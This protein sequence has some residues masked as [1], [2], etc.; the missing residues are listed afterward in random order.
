M[1]LVPYGNHRSRP[2]AILEVRNPSAAFS[3]AFGI[4]TSGSV[5]ANGAAE[6][7]DEGLKIVE[8]EL[9]DDPM[10]R[11]RAEIAVF[12]FSDHYTTSNIVEFTPARFFTAPRLRQGGPTPLNELIC[13]MVAASIERREQIEQILDRSQEANWIFLL[14][15]AFPTDPEYEPDAIKAVN[16]ALRC[17][18]HLFPIGCGSSPDMNYLQRISQPQRRP[19]RMR[20]IKKFFKYVARSVS[21]RS[22]SVRD[23]F[24]FEDP[25]YRPDNLGGWAS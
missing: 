2:P 11:D 23:K 9:K 16:L 15:D 4:D 19:L 7:I 13:R 22:R 20:D 6:E 1:N 12:T 14:T 17:R 25:E 8:F 24:H 21:Q 10:V 18:V 3:I 5:L